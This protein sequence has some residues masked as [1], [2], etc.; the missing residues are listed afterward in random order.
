MIERENCVYT[1]CFC[2][3]NVYKFISENSGHFEDM[4]AVFISNPLKQCAIWYQKMSEDPTVIPVCWDYH[5]VVIAKKSLNFLV[6]DLDTA[7]SFPCPLEEYLSQ[8]F[9][10]SPSEISQWWYQFAIKTG[11]YFRPVNSYDFLETFSSDR[12]HMIDKTTGRWN[13]PP[14]KYEPIFKPDLGSTLLDF[15]DFENTSL[16]GKWLDY[17]QFSQYFSN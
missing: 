17:D 14:P 13:S 8:C 2:E 7:L 6:Y 1:A 11:H 5:V 16:P 10:P 3:E 4:F 9:R 12:S 15:L